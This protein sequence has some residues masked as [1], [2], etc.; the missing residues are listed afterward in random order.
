MS[1]VE[2]GISLGGWKKKPVW[3]EQVCEGKMDLCMASYSLS[4]TL[5]IPIMSMGSKYHLFFNDR[6]LQ[7]IYPVQKLKKQ[8]K[9]G[10]ITRFS[11]FW[12]KNVTETKQPPQTGWDLEG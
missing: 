1:F 2:G 6:H 9:T 8:N 11:R 5:W 10:V 4:L 12:S 7:T 3:A